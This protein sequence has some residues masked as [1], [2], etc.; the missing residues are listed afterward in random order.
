MADTQADINYKDR[1]RFVAGQLVKPTN[2]R[3]P[4]MLA[5]DADGSVDCNMCGKQVDGRNGP[6]SKY[7]TCAGACDICEWCHG[8]LQASAGDIVA[9]AKEAEKNQPKALKDVPAGSCCVL[10]HVESSKVVPV[11][12]GCNGVSDWRYLTFIFRLGRG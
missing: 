6:T 3:N 2:E 7:W 11:R 9:L 10:C 12:G 8:A 4:H 5:A 1:V